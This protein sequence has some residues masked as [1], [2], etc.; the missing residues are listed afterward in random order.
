M[1]ELI[2]LLHALVMDLIRA[3]CGVGEALVGRFSDVELAA[4]ARLEA[5]GYARVCAGALRAGGAGHLV[6][7]SLEGLE[8]HAAYV[9]GLCS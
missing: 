5:A 9:A 8:A 2:D 1:R 3:G 6:M 4:Y 7:V